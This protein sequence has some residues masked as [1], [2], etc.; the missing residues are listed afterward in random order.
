[1]ARKKLTK[2]EKEADERNLAKGREKKRGRRKGTR[3]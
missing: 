3:Y 1:V 2:K